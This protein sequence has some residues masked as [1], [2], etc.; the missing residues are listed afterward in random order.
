MLIKFIRKRLAKS[1]LMYS[2]EFSIDLQMKITANVI[3]IKKPVFYAVIGQQA[4]EI[5]HVGVVTALDNIGFMDLKYS[6]C[7]LLLP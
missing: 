6:H 7:S 5:M 4:G 1:R 3:C 2:Y